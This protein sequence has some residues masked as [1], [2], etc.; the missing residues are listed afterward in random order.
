MDRLLILGAGGYG[1]TVAEAAE[2]SGAFGE[3]AFLD[4]AAPGVLVKCEEY[5]AFVGRF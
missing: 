4:D 3:I 2:Q 1:K 5:A